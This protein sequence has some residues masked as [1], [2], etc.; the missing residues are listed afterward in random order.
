MASIKLC[1]QGYQP[2]VYTTGSIIKGCISCAGLSAIDANIIATGYTSCK[3]PDVTDASVFDSPTKIT[4][5][6]SKIT[7]VTCDTN[8]FRTDLNKCTLLDGFDVASTTGIITK[9]LD[10]Y[11]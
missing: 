10:S 3:L 6:N 4:T 7:D 11:Y 1:S 8:Y 5:F 9:C 2:L